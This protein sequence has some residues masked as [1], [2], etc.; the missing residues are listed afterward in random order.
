MMIDTRL[1][2]IALSARCRNLVLG[3]VSWYAPI[4]LGF[5]TLP[6]GL[7]CKVSIIDVSSVSVVR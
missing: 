3:C 6:A 4:S 5:D 1:C 7:L 2:I